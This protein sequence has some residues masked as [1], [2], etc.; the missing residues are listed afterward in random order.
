MKLV[1]KLERKLGRFAIPNLMIYIII[2]YLIGFVLYYYNPYIYINYLSL[3]ARAILHGQIWRI[4]TYLMYPPSTNIIWM[5]LLSFIYYRIAQLMEQVMGTFRFNLYIFT[6][7]IGNVLAALLIYLIWGQIYLLTADKLYMSMLLALAATFPDMQFYL[8]FMIPVKAKWLGIFYGCWMVYEV[9]VSSWQGRI[10]I[11]MSLL[12]F[13]LY[14][15]AIRQPVNQAKRVKRKVVYQSKVRKANPSGSR[16]RCAVCGR[17]E[18]DNPNLEFRYCSKCEGNLE[19]C[20][21][22]LY[23]HKHVTKGNS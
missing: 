22:H 17:T 11:V 14:Y 16:H 5:A 23:T 9:L 10:A 19:Y 15:F 4:V 2:F 18:L 7:V 13:L 20:M 6:G 1:D 8:Y 21:D 12:N 3:N